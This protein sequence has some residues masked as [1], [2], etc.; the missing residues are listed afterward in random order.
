MDGAYGQPS[1]YPCC[2]S[3]LA[4]YI[5]L[6]SVPSAFGKVFLWHQHTTKYSKNLHL[7][8]PLIV[9]KERK[10]LSCN[11][12]LTFSRSGNDLMI[13]VKDFDLSWR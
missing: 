7:T 13:D 5:L 12:Y 1:R 4:I 6:A 11:R 9:G 8:V 2:S 3:R 10:P